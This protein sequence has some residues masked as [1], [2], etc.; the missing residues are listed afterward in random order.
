MTE[1]TGVAFFAYNTEQIDY[2]KLATVA[3]RYVKRHM[4]NR[5]VCLITNTGTWDWFRRSPF[6]QY[7]HAFDDIVLIEP[8]ERWNER[9]HYDS[10]YYKFVSEFKNGNKH[11]VIDYTP[12]DRTLLIDIDYV[13]QNSSLDYVFD[14]DSAVTLFH[15]AESLDRQPPPHSH[16]EL[17]SLGIPQLWSTAVYF[18]KNSSTSQMFFDIWGHVAD[19]YDFYRFLYGFTGSMYRTDYAVSI[20]THIMNGMGQGELIEDFPMPLINMGQ[21]DNIVK[22]NGADEWV[23]LIND[24]EQNWEDTPTLIKGENVHVMNKRAIERNFDDIMEALDE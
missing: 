6:S 23:Y 4:P 19:N 18:D 13:I 1:T 15:R 9:T 11:R 17:N 21:K 8:S 2:L 3:G 14:T 7:E 5:E 22:I 12:Y 10:P 20:A 16:Q 24:R